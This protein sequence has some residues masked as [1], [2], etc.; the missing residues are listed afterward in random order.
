MV[1]ISSYRENNL[2]VDI[3]KFL[4]YRTR[5]LY[6]VPGMIYLQSYCCIYDSQHGGVGTYSH[7]FVLVITVIL[8]ILLIAVFFFILVV[9][10]NF[11]SRPCIVLLSTRYNL[12]WH[13]LCLTLT[14]WPGGRHQR[15]GRP[16]D[17]ALPARARGRRPAGRRV[18]RPQGNKTDGT[19]TDASMQPTASIEQ[20]STEVD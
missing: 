7:F 19:R 5:Y 2:H 20:I 13:A 11:F 18:P 17:V 14:G 9:D 1:S 8:L 6:L 4:K 15:P 12:M 10:C 16:R 3:D